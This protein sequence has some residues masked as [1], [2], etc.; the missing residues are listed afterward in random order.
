MIGIA[1]SSRAALER[2]VE[3]LQIPWPQIDSRSAGDLP[4][5]Y[6]VRSVSTFILIDS[7]GKILG[8]N[9]KLHQIETLIESVLKSS[10]LLERG[11]ALD[12]MPLGEPA[13]RGVK[14]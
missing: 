12:E 7:Q 2:K 4:M 10:T 14:D 6:G 11:A 13:R 9:S 8:R 5:R 3:Q 1:L